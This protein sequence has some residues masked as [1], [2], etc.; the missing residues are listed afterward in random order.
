LLSA[1]DFQRYKDHEVIGFHRAL[2]PFKLE[3]MDWRQYPMLQQRRAIPPPQV[4]ELP[5]I[6]DI[7]IMPELDRSHYID[8]DRVSTSI[9]SHDRKGQV[10]Q[11]LSQVLAQI[12][13]PAVE[14]TFVYE[15]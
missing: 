10:A 8:P 15:P 1:Y 9:P 14:Q 4:A 7:P 13:R 5:A 6:A 11:Y 2:P 12:L 3:R